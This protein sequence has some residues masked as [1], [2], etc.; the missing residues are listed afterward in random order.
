M[1]TVLN[2]QRVSNSSLKHRIESILME[3]KIKIL[4]HHID[5]KNQ[6]FRHLYNAICHSK[7]F[8]ETKKQLQISNEAI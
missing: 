7:K 8:K 2:V 4:K 1:C 3:L 6:G 5:D